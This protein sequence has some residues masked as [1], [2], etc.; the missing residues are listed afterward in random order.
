MCSVSNFLNYS[1][2]RLFQTPPAGEQSDNHADEREVGQED[3]FGVPPPGTWG[4]SLEWMRPLCTDRLRLT[5]CICGPGR[6]RSLACCL[7]HLL[8]QPR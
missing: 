4:Y 8:T 3:D 5:L 6:L 1:A 2:D 7:L